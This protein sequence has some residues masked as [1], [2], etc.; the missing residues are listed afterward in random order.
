[1]H[2]TNDLPYDT[3]VDYL[4]KG[5]IVVAN[6]NNGGHFVLIT[7]YSDDKDSFAVNDPGYS[8]TQYSYSKDVVGY[9]IYD[10]IRD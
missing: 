9:R 8:T 5:R 7:G 3:I 2:R 6:V 10:M 4:N 1:M